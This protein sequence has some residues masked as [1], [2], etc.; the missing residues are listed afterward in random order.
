M[1]YLGDFLGL[2]L[3]E[4]TIARMQTD[5]ETVRIA[6]LYSSHPLLKTMPVPHVRL[7]DVDVDVPVL[8]KQVEEPRPAEPPRGGAPMAELRRAFDRVLEA[9]LPKAGRTLAAADRDRLRALLDASTARLAQPAD[10]AVDVNRI[11]DELAATTLKF[12]EALP[13]QPG[14]QVQPVSPAV[15]ADLKQAARIEF[16][17]LRKPPPRLLVLVTTTELREAGNSEHFTRLRL[18]V[19]EQGVEWTTVESEGLLQD[20]LV[21]E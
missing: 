15:A 7:P 16:L 6:E 2:I 4:I 19:T 9:Q 17:K 18:K 13:P 14:A 8:I 1:P 12:L 5:L 21:P 11:A 10:T 20:R 3:S